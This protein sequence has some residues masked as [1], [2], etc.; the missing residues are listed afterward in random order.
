MY[1][2]FTDEALLKK[3]CVCLCDDDNDLDTALSCGHSYVP[4]ITS[5]L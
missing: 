2:Q 4:S 5:N 1:R 3:F